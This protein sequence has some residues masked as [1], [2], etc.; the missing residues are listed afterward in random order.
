WNNHVFSE[1]N[2]SNGMANAIMGFRD[3]VLTAILSTNEG[4]DHYTHFRGNIWNANYWYLIASADVEGYVSKIEFQNTK[5]EKFI[6]GDI[7]DNHKVDYFG[8]PIDT[9]YWGIL[10]KDSNESKFETIAIFNANVNEYVAFG[11]LLK[12]S[13]L[14]SQTFIRN[15]L[16][17]WTEYIYDVESGKLVTVGIHDSIP[18]NLT[19]ALYDITLDG[20]ADAIIQVSENGDNYEIGN[21][22]DSISLTSFE[23]HSLSNLLNSTS[24]ICLENW[25][26]MKDVIDGFEAIGNRLPKVIKMPEQ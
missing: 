6:A 3:T 2:A 12:E 13:L 16:G 4:A 25:D 19:Y 10:F 14:K 9:I 1:E 8:M 7:N 15:N 21:A 24:K 22:S 11:P 17:N 5:R 26:Q 23:S 18:G 20:T